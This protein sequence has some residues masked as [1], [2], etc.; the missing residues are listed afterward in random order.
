LLS[1]DQSEEDVSRIV[2]SPLNREPGGQVERAVVAQWRGITV[3]SVSRRGTYGFSYKNSFQE[4]Y[5][6]LHD[7]VRADGETI[8]PGLG[9]SR[10]H[11]LRGRLTFLPAGCEAEGWTKS[12]DHPIR[13]AMMYVDPAVLARE[14]DLLVSHAGL[15]PQL[16]FNDAPLASAIAALEH[17]LQSEDSAVGLYA[18]SAALLIAARLFRL[19][20]Q[21]GEVAANPLATGRRFGNVDAFLRENLHR[22]ISLDDIAVIAGLSRFH[23]VKAFRQSMGMTPYQYLLRLRIAES[24]RMLAETSLTVSDIAKCVGFSSSTQFVRVFKSVEGQTPGSTRG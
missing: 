23:F 21:A 20:P 14:E 19:N 24:K 15:Q 5:V 10:E 13:V 1:A 16:Y 9:T 17:A 12:M 2:L 22:R 11:D 6:A 7:F 18:E 3:Q 8:V 4:H